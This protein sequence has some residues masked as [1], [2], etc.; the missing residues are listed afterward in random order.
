MTKNGYV[1]LIYRCDQFCHGRSLC[2]TW[3]G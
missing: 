2:K 3:W 1:V